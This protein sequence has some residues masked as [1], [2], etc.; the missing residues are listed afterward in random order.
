M[1]S[2]LTVL[3]DLSER[4]HYNFSDFPVYTHY[5][6]LSRYGYAA[7]CHW[8]PD[9]EFIYIVNGIMDYFINGEIVRMHKGEG[10]FINSRRLHY[11]FSKEHYE[12][13]F[14]A[15]VIHPDLFTKSCS[16]GSSYM[17]SRFS[18]ETEDYILLNRSE[19]WHEEVLDT[20]VKVHEMFSDELPDP[21]LLMSASIGIC[22]M[23]GK[24]LKQKKSE[25]EDN[26]LQMNFLQMTDYIHHHFSE[27]ITV[28]D[29]AEKGMVCRTDCYTLFHRYLKQTPA[30]YLNMY[31]LTKAK[32]LL[33]DTNLSISAISSFCG[34]TTPSYFTGTFRKDTGVTPK[35][36]R[37][38]VKHSFTKAI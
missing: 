26:R 17:S 4:L 1:E 5:D 14:I 37:R 9:L 38:N 10:I 29:I 34:F 20:I 30:E 19:A 8:H 11:G 33:R 15:L 7:L 25:T 35:E 23:I 24:Y 2:P 13:T 36:Y 21:L 3:E 28:K 22:A 16:A 27:K 6:V 32:E 18:F 12:C 31:R